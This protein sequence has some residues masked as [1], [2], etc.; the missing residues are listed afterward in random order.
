MVLQYTSKGIVF[1]VYIIQGTAC[2]TD[3]QSLFRGQ[4]RQAL[5]QIRH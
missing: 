1:P 3:I 4:I 2:L 5:P